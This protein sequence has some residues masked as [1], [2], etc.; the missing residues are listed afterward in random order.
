MSIEPPYPAE[1]IS[2]PDSFGILLWA[3]PQK[4]SG[5]MEDSA[6]LGHLTVVTSLW[7]RIGTRDGSHLESGRWMKPFML[8]VASSS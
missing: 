1:G 4:L 2:V 7:H 8:G 5:G 3:E 6:S